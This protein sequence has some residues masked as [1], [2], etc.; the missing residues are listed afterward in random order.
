MERLR[1]KE[2]RI[3]KGEIDNFDEKDCGYD[4]PRPFAKSRR[5]L[6]LLKKTES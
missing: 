1:E 5:T 2:E 6:E 3:K 4:D